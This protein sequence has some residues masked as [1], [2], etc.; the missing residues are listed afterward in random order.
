MR[1]YSYLDIFS[2][3]NDND[4]DMFDQLNKLDH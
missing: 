2:L 3:D 4:N 1:K